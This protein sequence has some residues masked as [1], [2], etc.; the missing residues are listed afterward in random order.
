MVGARA[1]VAVVRGSMHRVFCVH[2]DNG[3]CV[4]P[5]LCR[6]APSRVCMVGDG[7]G[8]VNGSMV[9][10]MCCS[11]S[12]VVAGAVRV[13]VLL[14]RVSTIETWLWSSTERC[15]D[16]GTH[17]CGMTL[18]FDTPRYCG[19][20]AD[21]KGG[22]CPGDDDDVWMPIFG[23]G[24]PRDS[25][26]FGISMLVCCSVECKCG[27]RPV[28]SATPPTVGSFGMPTATPIWW[29]C[30]VAC[31]RLVVSGAILGTDTASMWL[32]C[33]SVM[34]GRNTEGYVRPICQSVPV[35]AADTIGRG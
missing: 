17:W 15:T 6:E 8:V 7:K 18:G 25:D 2:S 21:P 33:T 19:M 11:A 29:W 23:M 28:C 14:I 9:M 30:P 12:C 34:D 10:L 32:V 5:P 26:R 4:C 1:T 24:N 20:F 16:D 22:C 3:S 35:T 31:V 27:G 13:V